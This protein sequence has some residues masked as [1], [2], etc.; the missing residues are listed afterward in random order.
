MQELTFEQTKEVSGGI[1]ETLAIV[2]IF[3]IFA[4]YYLNK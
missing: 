3:S 4:N 1:A 2:W